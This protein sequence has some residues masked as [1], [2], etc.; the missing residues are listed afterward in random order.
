MAIDA[1]LAAPRPESGASVLGNRHPDVPELHRIQMVLKSRD[2]GPGRSGNPAEVGSILRST[3]FE[4]GIQ[5]ATPWTTVPLR[6]TFTNCAFFV[7]VVPFHTD[8][9]N[10]IS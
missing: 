8:A 2:C 6:A 5:L 10:S 9:L 7:L 1:A 3:G 4:P